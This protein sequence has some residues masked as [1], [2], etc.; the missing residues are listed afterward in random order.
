MDSEL[1]V[2]KQRANRVETAES[3]EDSGLAAYRSSRRGLV[4]G[5]HEN[6]EGWSSAR[7]RSPPSPILAKDLGLV[8]RAYDRDS[9]F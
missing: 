9:G 6:K 4:G 2:E 3:P 1:L 7:F 8:S 5:G